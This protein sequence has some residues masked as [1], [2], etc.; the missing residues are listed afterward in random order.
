MSCLVAYGNFVPDWESVFDR[1]S[2]DS[3][4]DNTAE[5]FNPWNN[6][7]GSGGS[8]APTPPATDSAAGWAAF[9]FSNIGG[10]SAEGQGTFATA[11]ED[12]SFNAFQSPSDSAVNFNAF[13]TSSSP[14]SSSADGEQ[15]NAFDIRESTPPPSSTSDSPKPF[16]A[17]QPSF[18]NESTE[19]FNKNAFPIADISSAASEGALRSSAATREATNPF[20]A[21][22]SAAP[23]IPETSQANGKRFC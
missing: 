11:F 8:E 9:S 12:P 6:R 17:F 1:R 3:Q 14:L 15:F 21:D 5:A 13:P 16:N 23:I 18:S 2:S 4:G 7:G 20:V 22:F 19:A 10:S